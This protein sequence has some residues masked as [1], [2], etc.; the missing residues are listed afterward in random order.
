MN[1]YEMTARARKSIRLLAVLDGANGGPILPKQI[2]ALDD[3][4]WAKA[5]I[6]IG[7]RS[8]SHETRATVVEM[9]RE[10]LAAARMV[11]S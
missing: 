9:A 5:C 3:D 8:A 7:V 10:R 4:A 6:I 2:L 1:S 11:S